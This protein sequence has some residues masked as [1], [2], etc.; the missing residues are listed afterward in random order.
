VTPTLVTDAP[1][2]H[3]RWGQGPAVVL[4][5]GVGGGRQAWGETMSDTG[6]ALAAAGFT[7]LAVDLPGYGLSPAIEPYD[8]AGLAAAVA[9]LIASCCGSSAVLVGHSMGGMVAQELAAC[10]PKAV[11]ALVLASTSAAFGKAGGEWQ[12]EFLQARF[13][14]LDDG[15]GMA[16]LAA[17]L[18]PEMVAPLPGVHGGPALMPQAA[19]ARTRRLVAAQALMAGV[20]EATYRLALAAL[21]AFDRRAALAQIAVPTLVITGQHDRAAPPDVARGMAERIVGAQRVVLPDAGHL[22]NIEQPQAFHDA[23]LG[24]LQQPRLSRG[25]DHGRRSD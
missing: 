20:P 25:F 11:R 13:K 9:R 23:L 5:H 17:Q 14:P 16:G 18:V 8:L 2:A 7:A 12:R 15:L 19:A 10:A 22:I 1:L 3:L 21:V 6:A 4:L 24:F